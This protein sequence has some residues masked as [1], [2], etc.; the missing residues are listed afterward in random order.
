MEGQFERAGVTEAI[1]R[2]RFYPSVRAA[3]ATC[4]RAQEVAT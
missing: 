1:G 4:T 3:V 2:D